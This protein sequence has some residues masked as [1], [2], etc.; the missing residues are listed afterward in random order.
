MGLVSLYK[1]GTD[2]VGLQLTRPA[3]R[4]AERLPATRIIDTIRN[5]AG[6]AQR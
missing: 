4:L 2:F 5:Q 3:D 6:W 1:T